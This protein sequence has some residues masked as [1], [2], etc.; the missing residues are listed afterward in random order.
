[1]LDAQ[2]FNLDCNRLKV[3]LKDY[4]EIILQHRFFLQD[5]TKQERLPIFLAHNY[6]FFE[7]KFCQTPILIMYTK[8]VQEHTPAECTKHL[9]LARPHKVRAIII[10]HQQI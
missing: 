4:L 1:M 8:N 3:Q 6:R 2:Q 10:G 5:W 9:N 7:T